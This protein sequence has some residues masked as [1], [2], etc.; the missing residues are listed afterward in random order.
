MTFRQIIIVS[1]CSIALAAA[2]GG[3]KR[4]AT[5]GGGGG[6]PVTVRV[7]KPAPSVFE[8]APPSQGQRG[9]VYGSPPVPVE[10]Q[11]QQLDF[12][13]VAPGTV[14]KGRARIFNTGNQVLTITKS[15]TSCGCTNA[16]KL[17][18]RTIPPG[19]FIEF[20]TEL[21]IKSGLGEK[22]EKVTLLFEGY[23]N[24]QVIFFYTAEASRQVRVTPPYLP[25]FNEQTQQTVTSGQ[26]QVE[27][28]DGK[29]FT[30]LSAHGKTPSYAGFDPATDAPRNEYTLNWDLSREDAAGT[31]PWFWMLHT[32]HP[33]APIVDMR[34][35]HASTRPPRVK[36]RPWQPKDQRV[37]LDEVEAG[38]TIEVVAKIEF[39]AS[40]RPVAEMA[41]IVASSSQFTATLARASVDDRFL[42]YHLHITPTGTTPG[43]IYDT[44]TLQAAGHES[45]LRVVGM[46][47][48]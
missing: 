28:L 4:T 48:E 21:E 26:V 45:P 42:E 31:V 30:I 3:C 23:G 29:P 27:S 36:G 17:D 8:A 15:Y 18:G 10:F 41:A 2:V 46:L 9:R 38:E 14:A 13:I 16:E 24:Q 12:G 37:V 39:G 47:V 34:V 40:M 32:D 1:A 11:P 7:V 35:R 19:G 22:R 33:D 6:A 25:A 5:P 20:G 44:I 43:L